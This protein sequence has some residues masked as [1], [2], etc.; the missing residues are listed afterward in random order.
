M[1][2]NKVKLVTDGSIIVAIYLIFLLIVRLGGSLLDSIFFIVPLPLCVYGYKYSLK[3][4]LIVSVALLIS[5]LILIDPFSALLYIIPSTTIGLIYPLILKKK[6]KYIY[7]VVIISIL[8]LVTTLLNSVIF[9]YL[10]NY[11]IIEDTKSIVTFLSSIFSHLSFYYIEAILV[12]VIPSTLILSS[13]LEAVLLSILFRL[14]ISK[15][16]KLKISF[17]YQTTF[18]TMPKIIGYI[19]V[20]TFILMIYSIKKIPSKDNLF[21]LY[22]VILNI[23]VIYSF[24]IIYQGMYLI[25]KYSFHT[26]RNYLYYI[27]VL[28]L[29]IC[30]LIIL[31]IGI[32][33]SV[34]RISNKIS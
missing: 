30:P 4:S 25:S 10:F 16:N 34:F 7:E 28:L 21:I 11:D 33:Q 5:S 9:G 32:I 15:I 12:S 20:V 24:F 26:K 14:L 17:S 13:I 27:S 3:E 1:K 18:E 29:F 22:S 31:C 8:F 23:G 6:L 2:N 19:Y